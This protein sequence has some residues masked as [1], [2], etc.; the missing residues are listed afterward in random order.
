[1]VGLGGFEPPAYRL[2]I[3]CSIQLSYNPKS[4][5]Y[6]IINLLKYQVE[7]QLIQPKIFVRPELQSAFS[8]SFLLYFPV[9]DP[10]IYGFC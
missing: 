10:D 9:I 5:L 8:I 7:L 2:G 3:C 6:S 1:M 4:Y